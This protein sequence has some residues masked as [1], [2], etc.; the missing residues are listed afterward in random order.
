[1]YMTVASERSRRRLFDLGSITNAHFRT[2]LG[3]TR[4]AQDVAKTI[5]PMVTKNGN[6][7]VMD[8]PADF[9]SIHADQTRFRQSLLNLASNANKFTEKGTITIAA[10]QGQ[11]MAASGSQSRWRTLASA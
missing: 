11:G 3:P 8:C 6:R 5:E 2:E 10:H 9:G 4:E 1:M 7:L